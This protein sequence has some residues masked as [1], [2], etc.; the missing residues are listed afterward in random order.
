MTT[1]K[2]PVESPVIR[3]SVLIKCHMLVC[4]ILLHMSHS[5][6]EIIIDQ[7]VKSHQKFLTKV[8]S[9]LQKVQDLS[10]WNTLF[11]APAVRS[12]LQLLDLLR[13]I[14]VIGVFYSTS[15]CKIHPAD[16]PENNDGHCTNGPSVKAVR[17][18]H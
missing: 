13:S 16:N 9:E 3:R 15:P 1:W 5:M 10:D 11:L 14:V 4:S 8:I 7:S 17:S 2:I 18:D 6:E 12:Q